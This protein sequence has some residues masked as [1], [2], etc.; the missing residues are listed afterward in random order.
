MP[1]EIRKLAFDQQ[2]IGLASALS[3]CVAILLV[4]GALLYLRA[5]RRSEQNPV[6]GVRRRRRAT[7][8]P[9][10]R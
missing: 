9:A 8:L 2:D 1:I 7:R 10:R 5:Y 4:A 6:G 3:V